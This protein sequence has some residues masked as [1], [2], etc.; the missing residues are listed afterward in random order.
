LAPTHLRR[1]FSALNFLATLTLQE[2]IFFLFDGSST[3]FFDIRNN[4]LKIL[5]TKAILCIAC[6]TFNISVLTVNPSYLC[7]VII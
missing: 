4:I 2:P 1:R 7:I 5:N 6:H 3:F